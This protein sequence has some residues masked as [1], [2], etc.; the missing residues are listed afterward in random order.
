[1]FI[2]GF[3]RPQQTRLE[4][5]E[6][7]FLCVAKKKDSG[8]LQPCEADPLRETQCSELVHGLDVPFYSMPLKGVFQVTPT[9]SF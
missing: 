6:N 3:G 1:M 5:E 8:Y 9:L 7:S 4:F 2:K